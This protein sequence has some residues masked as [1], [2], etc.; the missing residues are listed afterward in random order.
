MAS[1]EQWDI[2]GY[3]ERPVP[4]RF[5]ESGTGGSSKLA[6][7]LPGIRYTNDAPLLYFSR[8][9]LLAQGY[10]VLAVDYQYGFDERFQS[11]PADAREKWMREDLEAVQGRINQGEQYESVVVVAKSLGTILTSRLFAAGL[12]KPLRVVW[13]TPVLSDE[14]VTRTLA[15]LEQPS[16]LVIGTADRHYDAETLKGVRQNGAVRVREVDGAGHRLE[17]EGDTQSS[18]KILGEYVSEL[19]SFVDT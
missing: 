11:L 1:I 13:L 17:I 12:N 15:S 10:D 14:G 4:N 7:L 19:H 9:L 16:L 18:I 6:L 3:R 8:T 2:E 5:F